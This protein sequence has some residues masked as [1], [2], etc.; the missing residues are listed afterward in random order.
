[1]PFFIQK[2]LLFSILVTFW[3]S[4][5]VA[6]A[7]PNQVAE[8]KAGFIV[9]YSQYVRWPNASRIK[10]FTICS[11]GSNDVS[12]ALVKQLQKNKPMFNGHPI[13]YLQLFNQVADKNCHLIYFANQ[14]KPRAG[15]T[16]RAILTVSD[17]PGFSQV[18]MIE[19]S[20]QQNKLVTIIN[21][22]LLQQNNLQASALL[23]QVAEIKH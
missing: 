10:P 21:Q 18:G 11:V 9:Q 17:A 4:L 3:G 7:A 16:G 22:A 13:Q 2:C 15:R 1:M 5:S 8:A 20:Q 12:D 6:H 14:Q 23:L 19:I